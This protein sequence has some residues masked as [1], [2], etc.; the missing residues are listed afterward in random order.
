M[1]FATKLMERTGKGYLSYSAIKYAADGSKNQDMK[2]FELYMKGYLKKDSPAMAFGSLYDCLLLEPDKL[3][4]KF[5]VIHDESVCEEIGGKSPRSTKVY[6]EWRI[7]EEAKA[8]ESGKRMIAEEDM[9]KAINMINRLDESEV[10]DMETGEIVPVR[11]Y[12][13]GTPQ[14]EINGWVDDVPIRGFLDVHGGSFISDSKTTRSMAG[15]RYDV[16]SYDY[17]IQAF[18]Y[19][20]HE[21][22]KDFYWVVQDTTSPYLCGVFK[23]SSQTLEFGEHKFRS[24]IA[25]IKRWLDT[26]EKEAHSFALYGEI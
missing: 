1:E 6:K 24:G 3:N 20:Y 22:V 4:D 23:A 16:R 7:V 14:Y 2:L 11:K 15:F 10:V 9:D 19:T 26:P 12:L 18:L 13:T 17:D 5:Y 8:L 21:S 25:N